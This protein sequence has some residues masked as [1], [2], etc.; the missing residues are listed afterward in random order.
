MKYQLLTIEKILACR[1]IPIYPVA[2]PFGRQALTKISVGHIGRALIMV[3]LELVCRQQP[4]I[5]SGE[6]A[7]GPESYGHA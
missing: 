2:D 7:I 3:S 6:A 4:R 5:G 1:L